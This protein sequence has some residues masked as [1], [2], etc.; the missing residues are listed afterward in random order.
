MTR[1]L[2]SHFFTEFKIDRFLL[3]VFIFFKCLLG[4]LYAQN[5]NKNDTSNVH[6]L[7]ARKFYIY[8]V[9]KGETLF[10][11]SQKF[12]IPQDE[13][14]GFNHE[15]E[16]TGL[17]VKM[18]LWIPAESWLKKETAIVKD[19][20]TEAPEKSVYHIAVITCL[21]ISK[22]YTA[23]DTSYTFIDEPLKKEIKEN[24]EFTE[25]V[26]YSAEV[27][28]SEGLKV[29]LFI[30]DSENDSVKLIYKL[31][32]YTGFNLIITNE[33]GNMLKC[34]SGFSS[35]R[36]IKIFSCGINTVDFLKDNKAAFSLNPSSGKQCEQMGKF[37][38]KYFQNS[39]LVTVK[40][41]TSKENERTEL[42]RSGWLKSQDKPVKQIDYFKNG[43]VAVADS[44]DKKKINVIFI[45]SSN[46][47]LVSSVLTVLSNK[48][49]E[50]NIRVIGLPTWQY[51]ETIDQKLIERCNVFLFSSGFI[52]Y[53][54][55]SVLR[56]RKY[57]R[58]KYV[59]EPS[60]TCYQG[61]DAFLVA[62]K[63]FL[64]NGKKM[65]NDDKPEIIKG[66]FSEYS[67]IKTRNENVYENQNIHVFQASADVTTDIVNNIN[68]K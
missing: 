45:S 31:K 51:F 24:L 44:L 27:L 65:L 6:F 21:N 1:I 30:I 8:K 57:F 68:W 58:D 25:G 52:E 37:A 22:I 54:T 14:M 53:N 41:T 38:G 48:I 66:L 39:L 29:H 9:D 55:E 23:I 13:I 63:L 32:K 67:F 3:L 15:I 35:A 4:E 61:Y 62:G 18:K 47:D 64:M 33:T 17:K 12:K 60:E 19:V 36:N 11:I 28:K 50:Y 46:E 43:A 7:N 5:L 2:K 20:I 10:S 42:F 49:P 40:T 26:L 56:F 34:I 16:K 59:L